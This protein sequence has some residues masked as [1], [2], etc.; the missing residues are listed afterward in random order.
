MNSVMNFLMK[1]TGAAY[2]YSIQSS[3]MHAMLNSPG[4]NYSLEN[5]VISSNTLAQ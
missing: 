3:P 1:D 5:Q 2:N 4:I